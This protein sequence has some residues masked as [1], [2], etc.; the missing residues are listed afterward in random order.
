MLRYSDPDHCDRRRKDNQRK[1]YTYYTSCRYG[2]NMPVGT[3]AC[4]APV[5]LGVQ[6]TPCSIVSIPAAFSVATGSLSRAATAVAATSVA[7]RRRGSLGPIT[8]VPASLQASLLSCVRLTA[9]R[10]LCYCTRVPSLQ[11]PRRSAFVFLLLTPLVE[12]ACCPFPTLRRLFFSG[13]NI[14]ADQA[15]SSTYYSLSTFGPI[16]LQPH[17]N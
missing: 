4:G 7:E 3:A 6:D 9:C 14:R 5:E 8:Y 12:S 17:L 16:T 10:I 2:T 15:T 11:Q 13:R 1:A